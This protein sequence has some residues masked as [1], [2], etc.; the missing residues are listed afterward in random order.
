MTG[1]IKVLKILEQIANEFLFKENLS[2]RKCSSIGEL[3]SNGVIIALESSSVT[4]MS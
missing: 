2:E 3:L 1:Q 4:Q